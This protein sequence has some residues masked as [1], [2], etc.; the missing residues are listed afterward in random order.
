MPRVNIRE[1]DLTGSDT[2]SYIENI[3]F[4]P[5]L[6]IE[7]Y[8]ADDNLVTVDGTYQ[9]IDAFEAQVAKVFETIN[10][11]W[12]SGYEEEEAAKQRLI[13]MLPCFIQDKGYAIAHMLLSYGLPIEYKGAYNLIIEREE[14]S[15][16][17]NY[18]VQPN[19]KE[20]LDGGLWDSI[21]K[22]YT[23]RGK[24]DP[25]FILPI[26][27]DIDSKNSEKE[28]LAEASATFAIQCAGNRGDAY[29]F[30][31]LPTY[32]NNSTDTD[33]WIEDHFTQICPQT[34]AR[35]ASTWSLN[36]STEVYG[37]YG[38]T[39]T[40]NFILPK[41]KVP[42]P[43]AYSE[44]SESVLK[45]YVLRDYTFINTVFPAYVDY[46]VSYAVNTRITPDWFAIAGS[47]RGVSPL[48]NLKLI[49]KYGDADIDLFQPRD[50]GEDDTN[51][52]HISINAICNI[53][54]YGDIIWGN[55]TM[56][57]LN[58]PANGSS[59][60][61]QLTAS[62]FLNIRSLCCDLKKTIYR[63]ARRYTFDPNSDALWI[64]FK[65]AITPL[66]EKMKANQG[67]RDYQFIKVKTNKKALL[68]ARII[69]TPIEA[70]ED[71]DVT[72]VLEDSI[73][74]LE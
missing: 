72:V 49:N 19:V 36:E 32:I 14:E 20:L 73:E 25:K 48:S 30:A 70:V 40:S 26:Y 66:L 13:E 16:L 27:V 57:P 60:A 15:G 38:T 55:R 41:Y 28:Q 69:I 71:F 3:A 47:V 6:K 39:F 33:K 53:R 23:D 29:A 24:Y 4:L 12:D 18:K 9:T 17:V 42:S 58:V 52:G 35:P 67:I 51:K 74:V 68:A 64:N 54:P 1:I 31:Y 2:R 11:V 34:I 8:D 62:D 50:G 63:A 22:Q 44:K 45:D 21:Y 7:G 37:S 46:L 10:V 61:V 5:A 65:S 43:L 56:H 59:D